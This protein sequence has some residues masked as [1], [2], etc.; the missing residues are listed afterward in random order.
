MAAEHPE[1]VL[2]FADEVWWSR[3]A[4]PGLRTWGEEPLRLLTKARARTDTE[5]KALAC[6][7][8]MRADTG[9]MLLRFVDG[10]PVSTVTTEFLRWV[11]GRLAH[12]GR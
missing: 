8:L 9:Q 7:G 6:Y 5:P 4:Q 2:G 10:R 1:W 12:D 11:C 3:L